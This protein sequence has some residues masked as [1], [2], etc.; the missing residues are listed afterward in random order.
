MAGEL[1]FG[2]GSLNVQHKVSQPMQEDLHKDSTFH[3]YSRMEADQCSRQVSQDQDVVMEEAIHD[4]SLELLYENWRKA[5]HERLH[6]A[7]WY[8]NNDTV[9]HDA[10]SDRDDLKFANFK[11]NCGQESMA[12]SRLE[13]C[14]ELEEDSN[15]FD[16][17]LMNE[18]EFGC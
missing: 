4:D 9:M 12:D 6:A 11:V 3:S 5:E 16:E 13:Y 1:L 14:E 15:V 17:A 8:F 18:I 7:N 2:R 10:D